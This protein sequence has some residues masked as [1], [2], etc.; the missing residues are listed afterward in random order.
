[1][2]ND[3]QFEA[4]LEAELAEIKKN[5]S[6]KPGSPEMEAY[7]ALG[8]P[9]IGTREHANELIKARKENFNAVP[10][11]VEQRAKAYLA[12]LDARPEAPKLKTKL[13]GQPDA[14]GA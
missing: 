10:W 13:S 3:R 5:H 12:A 9:D 4:K 1:M 11:E 2:S 6:I 14:R 8:Y 7:L